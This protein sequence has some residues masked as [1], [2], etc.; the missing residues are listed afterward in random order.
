MAVKFISW[1]SVGRWD[2]RSACNATCSCELV[3]FGRTNIHI[4]PIRPNN[5][6]DIVYAGIKGGRNEAFSYSTWPHF[7]CVCSLS[8]EFSLNS[9]SS[10]RAAEYATAVESSFECITATSAVRRSS[11]T[12]VESTCVQWYVWS[13]AVLDTGLVSTECDWTDLEDQ[14]VWNYEYN[15]SRLVV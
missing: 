1:Y 14:H 5:M 3:L 2:S 10:R 9:R 13:I 8:T 11:P 7:F 4:C 15:I 12:Q 6:A